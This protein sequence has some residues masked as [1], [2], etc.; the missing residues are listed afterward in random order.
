MVFS[1]QE[2]ALRI[3]YMQARKYYI[4]YATVSALF[5]KVSLH[6]YIHNLRYLIDS[7]V[8][9]DNFQHNSTW[10]PGV[11]SSSALSEGS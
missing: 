9:I 8:L 10:L 1:L 3:F 7:I 11:L 5:D 6:I 4:G 2:K